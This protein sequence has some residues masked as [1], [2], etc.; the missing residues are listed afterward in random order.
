MSF[1]FSASLILI[2]L[3]L[4][5]LVTTFFQVAFRLT[6][7]SPDRV[8]FQVASM[9]TG[10]GFTTQESELIAINPARRRLAVACMYTGHIFTALVI[11]LVMNLFFNLNN[12]EASDMAYTFF[13]VSL[14]VFLL[15][16]IL[17]LPPISKHVHN[18]LGNIAI[19]LMEKRNKKINVLTIRRRG[20][21]LDVTPDTI[22]QK[23]D[24][25][26]VFGDYQNIKDLFGHV[27]L[28]A[29]DSREIYE[30]TQNE[31]SVLDNYGDKAMCDIILNRVPAFLKD[32]EMCKTGLKEE[33]LLNIVML[34]RGGEALSVEKDTILAKNDEIVV[35]G[36]YG[37]IKELFMGD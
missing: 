10:A 20:H 5:M 17:K 7:L 14:G 21:V 2:V 37:L 30:K 34:K 16:A 18:I 13:F 28:K 24:L 33:Y 25:I 11:G 9:F 15:L 27:E 32:K 35:F 12:Q 4:Y 26:A 23:G 36:D 1:W 6:G 8:R 3:S 29:E 22:L 31:I 19:K